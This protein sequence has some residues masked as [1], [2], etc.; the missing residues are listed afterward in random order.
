M[1]YIGASNVYAHFNSVLAYDLYGFTTGMLTSSQQ[2]LSAS[3]CLLK[4][5]NIY[6]NPKVY[7]IDISNVAI[8]VNTTTTSTVRGVTDAMKY[9][10]NRKQTI[11]TMLQYV[12]TKTEKKDYYSFYYSFFIY[13]NS[14]KDITYNNFVSDFVFKGYVL[15]PDRVVREPQK[16]VKW[17]S[18]ESGLTKDN[19]HLYL[20]LIEYIKSNNL[21]VIFV[22]PI[23]F[24]SNE[25]MAVLNSAIKIAEDEGIK[26]INFNVLKD[27]DV[28]F[29]T[30]F[31]NANHLNV[32]GAIKY[33]KYFSKYLHENYNLSNHKKDK[34]Y[35][36]WNEEYKKFT[37]KFKELTNLTFKEV[38]KFI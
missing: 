8:D 9:S 37:N 32:Y 31:Y 38:L 24:F 30:D 34:N 2:P 13:H 21:D 10:K 20:D 33:T 28:D 22:V 23:R 14:W 36:S 11:D 7:V 17:I 1:L 25:N 3:K 26:T 15:T 18:E 12:D 6:Q 4:E 35:N 29:S 27:L 16:K 19:L 5:A